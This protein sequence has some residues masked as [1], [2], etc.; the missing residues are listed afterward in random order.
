[1]STFARTFSID[2]I[3]DQVLK[4]NPWFKDMLLYWRPAGDALHRDM[5][6]AQ[7]LVTSGQMQ[8]EDPKR[9]RMAIRNG[10]LNLYRGGQSVAKIRFGSRGGLEARIHNKYVNGDKGSGYAYVTLTSKGLHDQKTGWQRKYSGRA[11]LDEWV[12]NVNKH[13]NK[14]VRKEKLFVD[15]VVARNPDTIDL[16]MALPACPLDPEER[17]APRMDLVALEPAGDHRWRIV[18]WEAKLVDDPRARCRGDDV[19]PKVVDQLGQYTRWLSDPNNREQVAFAYQKACRLLAEF[20]RHAKSINPRIEELGRGI[21]EAAEAGAP[22][23]LIDD[24]PRLLID[25]RAGDASFQENGHLRKLQED[26][27]L[28]VQIVQDNSQ[29]TLKARP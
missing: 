8:E 24:K 26:H 27:R 16:E 18:F 29:M 15:L 17:K 22:S 28:H 7:K 5:T 25:D 23:L 9:L 21:K 3:N 12:S 6:E 1:M 20:R 13:I 4:E 14:H 2:Q 19:S 11:D 10:Y